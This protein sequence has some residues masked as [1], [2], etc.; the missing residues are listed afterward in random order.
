MKAL[1]LNSGV[2]KRM[3]KLTRERPKCMTPIGAGHTI[4]S[5]QLELLRRTDI[6]D[7]VITTGPFA[8]MLEDYAS[9]RLPSVKFI[10]NPRYNETNYIYSMHLARELLRDDLILLHGDLVME[11]SVLGKLLAVPESAVAVEWGVPLPEKDFKARLVGDRVREIGVNVFGEDC[12][13]SQPAYKLQKA[14]MDAWLEAISDFC[15]RGSTDVYAEN[16]LNSIFNR[17]EMIPVALGGRLCGE[18]DNL[19]DLTH[20]SE[21]FRTLMHETGKTGAGT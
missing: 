8:G 15:R 11:G 9:E 16:A 5:W 6:T 10:H 20:I 17:V 19:E 1:I 2:G 14:D 3:G 4:L 12:V 7:I 21:R 18:I 13:A